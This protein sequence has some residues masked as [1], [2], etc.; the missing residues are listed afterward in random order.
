MSSSSTTRMEQ[1]LAEGRFL[2]SAELTPPRH[3]DLSKMLEHAR[4]IAP[5]VDV[6]QLNDHLLSQARCSNIIAGLRV[7]EQG[8]EPVLQFPLRHKNRIEIQGNLLAMAAVGLKNLIYL[9]GYPCAIGT[10]PESKEVSDLDVTTV[11]ASTRRL[12]QE[13]RL[14]NGEVISPGPHYHVGTIDFPVPESAIEGSMQRLAAKIDAGA[15]FIQVQAVFELASMRRWM[16]AVRERGLDRRAHFVAAV[17]PFAGVDRLNFLK[18]VPGLAVPEDLIERVRQSGDAERAS[19]Q[20]TL[21]LIQGLLDI[22]GLH[23]L[24]MRAISAED[25]V[26]RLVE[27]ARLRGRRFA[28]AAEAPAAEVAAPAPA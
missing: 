26:P 8:L 14:F 18:K 2:I 7:L 1:A 13:G 17:F 23:G 21:E 16:A 4:N 19:Y 10:D 28:P 15:R 27:D 3:F 6:A 20:I 24:H 11:I 22:P 12:S 9:G 25:W 5:H